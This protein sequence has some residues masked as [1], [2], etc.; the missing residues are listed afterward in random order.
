MNKSSFDNL[1]FTFCKDEEKIVG[2]NFIWLI[3]QYL[4]S[5]ET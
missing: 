3:R 1:T 2:W 5:T 4:L